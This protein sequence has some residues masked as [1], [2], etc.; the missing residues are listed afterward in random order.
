MKIR[1]LLFSILISAASYAQSGNYFLSHFSSGDK[2]SDNICFDIVQDKR[3]VFYFATQ[4]GVLQFDG[5]N[6]DVIR[7]SGAVYSIDLT[8][9]GEIFVGGSK[10]FGK[11]TNNESG[12]ET[13]VPVYEKPGAENIFQIESLN[14]KVYF[15][16]D[17]NLYQYLVE[18]D[19][20]VL[21]SSSAENNF[22]GLNEIFQSAYVSTEEGNLFKLEAD[23]L[24]KSNLAVPDS[25]I[26]LFSEEYEG[27][28]ILGTVDSKI[29][30]G[31]RSGKLAELPLE[32]ESYATAS[33]IINA[34]W[35]NT[36]LIA[37][38]TL[39]GGII[40]INPETGK[41]TEII[42]YNTGLPDNEVYT[43]ISDRNQNVWA[44]HTYGFTRIAPYLPMRSF[45]YYSGLQGNLLCATTFKGNVYVGSSLGLY[46]L[47]KEESY[48]DIVYYVDVLVKPKA[49]NQR[50][51]SVAAPAPKEVV[52]EKPEKGGFF[53]FLKKK[54]A[55]PP[56][57]EVKPATTTSTQ[58][59]RTSKP[60]AYY[61]REMRTKKILRST[62]Y[63]YK[64]VNG[65]NAKVT[66]L[67]TW[68]GKL[69]AVGLDGAFEVNE[70]QT[71]PISEEPVRFLFASESKKM[72]I[73]STYND[74]LHQISSDGK[75]WND[76][77]RIREV[78]DPINYIFEE[79]DGGVWFC[80]LDKVYRVEF[81]KDTTK[82]TT[83]LDVVNPN[84]DKVAGLS[85]DDRVIIAT[86]EG[87]YFYNKEKNALQKTDSIAKL[88][89]FFAS[90]S[91]LWFRDEHQWSVLG[92]KVSEANLQFLNLF[93]DIRFISSDATSGNVWIITGN[94]ELFRFF[95][96]KLRP[97][98]TSYPI[99]L[100]SIQNN[101]PE[102]F[103]KNALEIDQENSSLKIEVIKP[104]YI[105]ARAV[106]YR[107]YLQGLNTE[108]SAWSNNNNV[109]DFPYLPPGEYT[110]QFQS[111]DIFGKVSE[112]EPVKVEVLPPYWKRMWFYALEF[113]VFTFL[114]LLSFRLSQ[115]YNVVSRLLS[116]LSIIILI[117][118]IQTAA[119]STFTT[120]SGP[121]VDFLIQVCVA[122]VIL[123]VEGF[124]RKFMLKS[125]EKNYSSKA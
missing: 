113:G 30:I 81:S 124:L 104:D 99:F 3:G 76:Q 84:F 105:G 116:L 8:E 96:Q 85:L 31:S 37:L 2:Q 20:V 103:R 16:N 89:S 108:W 109:I 11:I 73:A 36:E 44:A 79:K 101:N 46:K 75:V 32:D 111:K 18:T 91:T 38:G 22:L 67:I 93:N 87:F 118:F 39:R 74:K 72:L 106:E 112:M 78:D 34:T 61:K 69:I 98:E 70:L 95:S 49:R 15:L 110:L 66:Q 59:K 26:L 53:K 77:V 13:F 6:W 52:E 68:Q 1:A 25:T 65:I 9:N 107:Y 120:N 21:V 115:R 63:V 4:A 5:R 50:K 94:N 43:L 123:P 121:V 10:G 83:T 122:F 80:S 100:K 62:S 19:S 51:T 88:N 56:P 12:L 28:Y 114:V 29:F 45:R 57:A 86:S 60:K 35:V 17:K 27:N 102:R 47:E 125:I 42:N 64:K 14:G 48:D 55:T 33:E 58:P 41:T 71:S 117:E 119:G 40:F 92:N 82:L 97:L 90:R 23:S 54:K 7:T 24:V